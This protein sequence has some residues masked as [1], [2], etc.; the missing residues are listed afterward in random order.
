MYVVSSGE[1][2]KSYQQSSSLENASMSQLPANKTGT[3]DKD[4]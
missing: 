3:N 4:E 2:I 1:N